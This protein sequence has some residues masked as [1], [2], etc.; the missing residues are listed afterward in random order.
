MHNVIARIKANPVV[1]G[2]G[3]LLLIIFFI[4]CRPLGLYFLC[5]DFAHI[6]QMT[7][8]TWVQTH[9]LRPVSNIS[10]WIDFHLWGVTAAGYHITNLI[11]HLVNVA[12]I[13]LLALELLKTNELPA[14]NRFLVACCTALFFLCY[15]FHSEPLFWITGRGGSLV[16]IFIQAS[17]LLYLKQR[18][19]YRLLSIGCFMLGLLTYELSWVVPLLLTAFWGYQSWFLKK[20]TSYWP[21]LVYW[22]LLAVYLFVRYTFYTTSLGLYEAGTLLS[23]N[24]FKLAYNYAALLIRVFVPPAASSG[25]F[26]GLSLLIVSGIALLFFL[27]YKRSK[28][29]FVFALLMLACTA[30]SLLPVV[31]M[32][33]D[34]H[35]S[36]S[37]RFIYPASVFACIL[38]I[39]LITGFRDNRLIQLATVLLC[40]VHLGMLYHASVAYRYASYVS[41]RT[42]TALNEVPEAKQLTL[43]QLPTQ[44]K[45][46]LIFRI[47]F[48]K[49]SPGI[50]KAR[51]DSVVIRSFQEL[52]ER[53]PFAVLHDTVGRHTPQLDVTF[54]NDTLKLRY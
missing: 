5:D 18:F 52:T 9:L 16:A 50:L 11:F 6:P 1:A 25:W 54:A 36:E 20:K 41:E 38:T 31:S 44:Y 53:K 43:H 4:I 33:I 51:Y 48:P 45:G 40:S 15:A 21:V 22:M 26:I 23:S 2:C 27:L 35:D 42:I 19:V 39:T 34:T 13:F 32:G 47:G 10:L 12:L 37:E 14:P 3:L 29:R 7:A 46:A 30:I 49:T 28:A 8:R 17:V 24:Y